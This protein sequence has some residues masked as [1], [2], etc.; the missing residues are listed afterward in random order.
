MSADVVA[1]VIV[2]AVF[3][4]FI[5]LIR[6]VFAVNP[7]EPLAVAGTPTGAV[8]ATAG[9][10]TSR[11]F[12]ISHKGETSATFTRPKKPSM[13]TGILLL[14]LGI[15]P[16]LLYFGLFRG[17]QTTTVLATSGPAGT[18]LTLSGDDAKGRRDLEGWARDS[19]MRS[20]SPTTL[21]EGEAAVPAEGAAAGQR[22]RYCANCGAEFDEDARFCSSCGAARA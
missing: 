18:M 6:K 19:L 1:T 17:T 10:M 12:A 5:V 8:E 13:E 4:G 3:G 21:A 11:G 20:A 14:L 9:F 2:L 16:G 7:P 22:R 15:I